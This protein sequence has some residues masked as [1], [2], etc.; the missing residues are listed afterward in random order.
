MGGAVATVLLIVTLAIV[1]PYM[2]WS[3]KGEDK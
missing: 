3:L 2:A 1:I